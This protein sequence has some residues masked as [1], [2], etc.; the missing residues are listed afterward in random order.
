MSYIPK[1]TDR[2]LPPALATQKAE[3]DLKAARYLIEKLNAQIAV[4]NVEIKEAEYHLSQ[5]SKP[6]EQKAFAKLIERKRKERETLESKLRKAS[7]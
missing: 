3:R 4:I 1:K 5:A 2:Y 6:S 7:Q